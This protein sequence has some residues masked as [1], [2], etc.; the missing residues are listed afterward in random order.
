M[1][2]IFQMYDF[3]FVGNPYIAETYKSVKRQLQDIAAELQS[4]N[5]KYVSSNGAL[6]RPTNVIDLQQD[7]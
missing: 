6:T 3:L 1:N 4:S 5:R 7:Y 2:E